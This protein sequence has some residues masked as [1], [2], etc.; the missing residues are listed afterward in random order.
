VFVNESN[1]PNLKR[2]WQEGVGK[3]KGA[4][5]AMKMR[6]AR[7]GHILWSKALLTALLSPYTSII[8]FCTQSSLLLTTKAVSYHPEGR[9]QKKKTKQNKTK[10][11]IWR[12]NHFL[13]NLKRWKKKQ[14]KMHSKEFDIQYMHPPFKLNSLMLVVTKD[15]KHG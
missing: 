13:H 4:K 12:T 1:A 6:K 2:T 10:K 7:W 15:I 3:E 14:N 8:Y 9:Y 5:C 11:K